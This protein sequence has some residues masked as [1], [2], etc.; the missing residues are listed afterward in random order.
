M[1]KTNKQKQENIDTWFFS[2]NGT[3]LFIHDKNSD[4][5]GIFTFQI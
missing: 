3:I 2:L 1:E 5:C 4:K